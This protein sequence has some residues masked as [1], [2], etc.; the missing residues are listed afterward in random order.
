MKVAIPIFFR[1]HPG[2]APAVYEMLLAHEPGS[3][4]NCYT[5]V[6]L[7]GVCGGMRAGTPTSV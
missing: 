7:V 1:C 3:R 4:F 5:F 6:A 2:H